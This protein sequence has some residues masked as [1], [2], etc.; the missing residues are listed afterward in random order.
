MSTEDVPE[1]RGNT[2][3]TLLCLFIHGPTWDGDVPSKSGRDEL[4]QLGL[5]SRGDGYQWL[6][7]KGARLCLRLGFAKTKERRRRQL[8][9]DTSRL[10]ARV[11][12]LEKLL[13]TRV[14]IIAASVK[15]TG[16][17]NG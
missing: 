2:N 4:V 8:R 6:T 9:G 5:A 10:E 12:E 13:N 14:K 3:E 11:A 1:L 15:E 16:E 17:F 7:D